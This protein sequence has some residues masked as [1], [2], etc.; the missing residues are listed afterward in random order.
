MPADFYNE[1]GGTRYE[2]AQG[3]LHGVGV[4]VIGGAVTTGGTALSLHLIC[5]SLSCMCLCMCC[6]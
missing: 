2:K 5:T 3:A 6:A 4:S 1:M